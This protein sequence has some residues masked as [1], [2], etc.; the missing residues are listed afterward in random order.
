MTER[1]TKTLERMIPAPIERV[2][3]LWTTA[4]GIE[5]WWAP[6]GFRADVEKLDLREGG[7]LLYSLTAVAPEQIAFMQQYGLPLSNQSRKTFT[8]INAPNRI[9]YESLA[10]FIPDHEP[11]QQLTVVDLAEADGGTAVTMRMEPMHDEVW[12]ERLIAGRSNELDN[13]AR[14]V[15]DSAAN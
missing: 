13:L 11:Y 6:E 14:L 7:E 15:A 12:T 4:A 3:E 1:T 10:D 9:A 2:W 8:E 5:Q